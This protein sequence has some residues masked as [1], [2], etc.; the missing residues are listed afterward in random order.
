MAKIVVFDSGRGGEEVVK[1]LEDELPILEVKRV[2]GS[3]E[4]EA[5]HTKYGMCVAIEHELLPY[6]FKV[7]LIVLGGFLVSQ[8]VEWLQSKY[9]GQ[10]FVAV[11]CD[12]EELSPTM[13]NNVMILADD[14]LKKTWQ[15]RRLKMNFKDYNVMEPQCAHW[16]ELVCDKTILGMNLRLKNELAKYKSDKIDTIVIMNTYFTKLEENLFE[17]FGRQIWIIDFKK[18]LRKDI[19]Q[20]KLMMWVS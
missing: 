7:D 17:V 16:R 11:K 2:A 14:K 12:L 6:I 3:E 10:K 4:I 15:Y 5:K 18:K 13:M 1:Y 9:P 8:V 19:K 20:Q